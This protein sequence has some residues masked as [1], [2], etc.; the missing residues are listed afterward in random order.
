[1]RGGG[2]VKGGRGESEKIGAVWGAE[3]AACTGG[4]GAA[5][6]VAWSAGER[7]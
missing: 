3:A 5:K 1:V 4:A 6:R 7:L 2:A